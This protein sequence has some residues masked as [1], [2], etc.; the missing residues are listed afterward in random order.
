[1]ALNDSETNHIVNTNQIIIIRGHIMFM[2]NIFVGDFPNMTHS[3]LLG[4]IRA[5]NDDLAYKKAV[6]KFGTA[7]TGH[8]FCTIEPI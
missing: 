7:L 2:F 3:T 4:H 5:W 1:M 6:R 8:V